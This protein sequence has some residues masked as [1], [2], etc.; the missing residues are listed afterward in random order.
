MAAKALADGRLGKS[1]EALSDGEL[2]A[3]CDYRAA[4]RRARRRGEPFLLQFSPRGPVVTECPRTPESRGAL[5]DYFWRSR[6]EI[7]GR[8]L[9]AVAGRLP[10]RKAPLVLVHGH[11]HVPDRGQESAISLAAGH[12]TIPSQGFSPAR[13]ALTPIAINGGAWQRT[14]TPVQYE[15]LETE[16]GLPRAEVM[17]ALQPD[18]LA[19]CYGFVNVPPYTDAPVPSVRYWRQS[20][21]GE[22][23]IAAGCGR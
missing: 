18:D 22:W 19:P 6:D 10:T 11:T 13:G 1:V 2:I 12:L 3:L 14:I 23:G 8:H 4:S 9:E 20:S 5:F 17:R 7:F 21:T 16:R 15:R